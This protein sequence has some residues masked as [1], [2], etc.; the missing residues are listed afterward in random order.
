MEPDFGSRFYLQLSSDYPETKAIF[1]S[2]NMQAQHTRFIGMLS[3]IMLRMKND[4]PVIPLVQDLG[5]QHEHYGVK[6]EHFEFFG[7]TLMKVL[8]QVLGREFNAYMRDAWSAVY[9]EI[10]RIMKSAGNGPS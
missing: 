8:Q 7:A 9:V 6:D 3:L 5:K 10:T 1:D 4:R 2:I